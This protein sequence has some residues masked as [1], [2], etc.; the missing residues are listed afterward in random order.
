MSSVS[1]TPGSVRLAWPGALSALALAV[2][3][4]FASGASAS[5]VYSVNF[6]GL[7]GTITT[8]G[9]QGRLQES[10]FESFNLSF[11]SRS[12]TPGSVGCFGQPCIL[13]A[14]STGLTLD[15]ADIM[16][17]RDVG[18]DLVQINAS[19][20]GSVRIYWSNTTDVFSTSDPGVFASVG[21]TP[22]TGVPEPGALGLVG[23]GLLAASVARRRKRAA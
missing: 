23:A 11:Q 4:L 3:S 9:T 10:N 22:P 15:L 21:S 6:G 12:L 16:L 19:T 8:D 20:P 17:F 13:S 18:N 7:T 1:C 14:S 2:G 5:L